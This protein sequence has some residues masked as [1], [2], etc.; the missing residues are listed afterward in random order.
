MHGQFS[1]LSMKHDA[2]PVHVYAADERHAYLARVP[3]ETRTTN[4]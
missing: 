2:A 1:P 3:S 4:G